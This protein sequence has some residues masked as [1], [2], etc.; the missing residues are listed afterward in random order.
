M[1]YHCG[2]LQGLTRLQGQALANK[3]GIDYSMLRLQG[4]EV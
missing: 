3:E 1:E 4:G 2:R